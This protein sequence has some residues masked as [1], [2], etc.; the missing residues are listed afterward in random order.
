MSNDFDFELDE[1][2]DV[3]PR[4]LDPNI[5]EQLKTAK[6]IQRERDSAL[7]EL[8]TYKRDAEFTKM[9]IPDIGVGRLFRKAYDGDVTPEAVLAAA[10]EYGILESRPQDQA[11]HSDTDA[12]LA[13]LA[14]VQGATVGSSGSNPVAP[15]QQFAAGL[16]D[17]NTPEEVMA[18]IQNM[19]SEYP[20]AGF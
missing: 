9:G 11:R 4:V 10:K 8:E 20:D 14:R 15:E 16:A 19:R 12:E 17:A 6:R 18:F 1:T 2:E 5:R 13:Q 3:Q 7:A